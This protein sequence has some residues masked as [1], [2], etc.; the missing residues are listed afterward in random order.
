M[1]P[2][3]RKMKI[4][5]AVV[6]A[7]IRTGEPVGSKTLCD[8]L[9]FS[10]SSATIRND[11]AELA[12]LGLLEQTHTSSGRVPTELGY[13]IY[14]DK[15]MKTVPLTK[16]EKNGLDDILYLS[17]DA[18]EHLLEEAAATLSGM[19]GC[20]V[21]A[22]SPSAEKALIRRI[23]FVQTGGC[24]AM[25]VLITSTGSVKTKLFRCD[26][27]ITPQLLEKLE[28][29]VNERFSGMSVN[30]VTPAF[31]QTTAAAFGEMSMLMA[32]A[33]TA[34]HEAANEAASTGVFIKGQANL[35]TMPELASADAKRVMAV[36]WKADADGRA[37]TLSVTA[38]V[39]PAFGSGRITIFIPLSVEPAEEVLSAIDSVEPETVSEPVEDQAAAES[40]VETILN[41]SL[42]EPEAEAVEKEPTAEVPEAEESFQPLRALA[43][44]QCKASDGARCYSRI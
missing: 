21:I 36:D 42:P 41:T 5:E 29:T 22:S 15:L 20:A 34:V 4:L 28:N 40:G 33:L 3:Q 12:S 23:R 43:R 25:T 11:M 6:E 37:G 9:D 1:E 19:T 17:A 26:F 7:Y 30:A 8:A 16:Y 44:P 13:R 39:S 18:P 27:V 32:N 38:E 31:M 24:T 2:T 10:V 14:V 35:F